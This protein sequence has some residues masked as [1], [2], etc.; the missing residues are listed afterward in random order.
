MCVFQKN[1]NDNY[2]S[3]NPRALNLFLKGPGLLRRLAISMVTLGV[4]S[5]NFRCLNSWAYKIYFEFGQNRLILS[6]FY[7]F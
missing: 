4:S 1:A 3:P 2:F 5:S 7:N 6:T